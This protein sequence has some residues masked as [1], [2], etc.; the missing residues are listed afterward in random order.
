MFYGQ[1]KLVDEYFS[2]FANKK[3]QLS[4]RYE[5]ERKNNIT[6]NTV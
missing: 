1:Q 5:Y 4:Q 2:F 3:A 6:V